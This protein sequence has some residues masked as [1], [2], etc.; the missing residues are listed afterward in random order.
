MT[1]VSFV[2][3]HYG[4]EYL[5]WSLRALDPIVDHHVVLYSPRPSFGHHSTAVCPDTQ[6]ELFAE[7]KR[8][9]TKPLHW[10][11]DVWP[12]EGAHRDS[13]FP[14]ARDLGADQIIVTDSD[15][16]WDTEQARAALDAA[17]GHEEGPVLVRFAHF[18][19]SFKWICRDECM[20][21]R[22]LNLKPSGGLRSS[23]SWY[24]SPQEVPVYH[25]GYAQSV[26]ITRYKWTCHGHQA[27]FRQGWLENK[28]I[29]WKPGQGDVHPTN[30]GFWD[31]K[32]T[33][34]ATLKRLKLLLPG[35]PNWGK[36]L[37]E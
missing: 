24:L 10:R 1:R 17:A 12:N 7:A 22:I 3:L 16:V 6:P 21:V 36:D 18:Y 15:E 26:A 32:P 23:R 13:V 25:F 30:F 9:I 35:H 14:I 5:A 34:E 8:F 11:A 19:R 31:P 4:K 2:C 20:P 37:I 33:D 27:E 29:G 28:Y